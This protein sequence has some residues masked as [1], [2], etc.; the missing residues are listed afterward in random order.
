MPVIIDDDNDC[1]IITI[2]VS[3]CS[4]AETHNSGKVRTEGRFKKNI[5]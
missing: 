3:R 2:I 4:L 5:P 1:K